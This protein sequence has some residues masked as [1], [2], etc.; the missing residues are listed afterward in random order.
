ML[1]TLLR[2]LD[3]TQD[4]ATVRRTAIIE[5]GGAVSKLFNMVILAIVLYK[6]S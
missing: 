1:I 6:S 3:K 2:F 5:M 4:Y